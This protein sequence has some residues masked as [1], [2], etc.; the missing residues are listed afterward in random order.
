MKAMATKLDREIVWD[1]VM[2]PIKS[3][4]PLITWTHQVT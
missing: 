4:N 1:K 2:L 3:H